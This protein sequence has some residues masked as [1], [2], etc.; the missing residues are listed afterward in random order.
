MAYYIYSTVSKEVVSVT[1]EAPKNLDSKYDYV[2]HNGLNKNA[3]SDYNIYVKSNALELSLKTN[4]EKTSYLLKE[5]NQSLKLALVESIEMME[6]NKMDLQ[7]A[8]AELYEIIL[9]V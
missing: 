9:E 5:E 8:I 2:E 4:S 1:D 3:M 7:L 6:L